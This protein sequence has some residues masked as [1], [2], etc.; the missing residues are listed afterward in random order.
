MDVHAFFPQTFM[1]I[2]APHLHWLFDNAL[3]GHHH[4]HIWH[5][6]VHV[7]VKFQYDP[8]SYCWLMLQKK[9]YKSKLRVYR[10]SSRLLNDISFQK[11]PKLWLF[12]QISGPFLN[13]T[14]GYLQVIITYREVMLIHVY[15]I[16]YIYLSNI[17]QN[18]Y[19]YAYKK[20]SPYIHPPPCWPLLGE[21]E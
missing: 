20:E 9:I 1:Y 14:L 13:I 17:F 3:F 6:A 21:L 12:G 2:P 4:F 5:V 16:I 11:H 8:I 19:T 18:M 10:C 15:I 7:P